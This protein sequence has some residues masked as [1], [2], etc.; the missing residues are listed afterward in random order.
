[1]TEQFQRVDALM[2]TLVGRESHNHNP[3]VITHLF[4]LYNEVFLA[5]EYSKSCGGCRERVYKGLKQWWIDNGGV[6]N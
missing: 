5:R 1:M 4:N 6:K 3:E 2:Q